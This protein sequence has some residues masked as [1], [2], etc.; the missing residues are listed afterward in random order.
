MASSDVS[1]RGSAARFWSVAEKRRIVEL[2]L[3]EGASIS[4][5]ARAHGIH[6]NS[7][8]RWRALYR[9]GELKA[10]SA[11]PPRIP[12]SSTALLPV[13]IATDV[14]VARPAASAPPSVRERRISIV[15][16]TLP[17]GAT[18]RLESGELDVEVL[19]ALLAEVR[20]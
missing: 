1:N 8:S 20:R 16:F 15:Q 13:T 3:R 12:A 6:Y 14:R 9:A 18:F 5:I 7:V 10:P 11:S 2:T 4:E 17:S 19:S